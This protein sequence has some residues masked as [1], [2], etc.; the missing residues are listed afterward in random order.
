MSIR[1]ISE[2]LHLTYQANTQTLLQEAGGLI[3]SLW[4]DNSQ[5]PVLFLTS[6]GSALQILEYVDTSSLPPNLT[7]GV[8]DER[9]SDDPS[10]SNFVALSRT[11]F[12]KKIAARKIVAI[13]SRPK[14]EESVE[15]LAQR[16]ESILRQWK[17]SNAHGLTLATLGIG[18]DGHI[19]GIMPYPENPE[20]FESI[21][22]DPERFVVGYD[23]TGKNPFPLRV[24]VTLSFLRNQ[25][26]AAIVYVVGKRK[27]WALDLSVSAKSTARIPASIVQEMARVMILTDISGKVTLFGS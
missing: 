23:A 13:D 1:K 25:V 5:R 6:A 21:F 11:A 2:H 7:L 10:S 19:A 22:A 27:E 15:V 24:T 3:S 14:R 4:R 16:I 20:W 9:Y 12:F 17:K 26:D 8:I 18:E